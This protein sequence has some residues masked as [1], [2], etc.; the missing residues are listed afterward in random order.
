MSK[1]TDYRKIALNDLIIGKGQARV[2]NVGAGIEDLADSIKVQG[3]LQP[4][5]VC[6]ALQEGKWEILSGQRRFL[7][8]KML[9]MENITAAILDERVEEAEAKAISITEN[10]IRRKLSGKEL[11]D[12]ITYLYRIYGTAKAVADTT[13]IPYNDVL[14]YV[15]YPRLV[16]EMKEMVDEGKVDVKV[17]LKA[18]D[19]AIEDGE[20]LNLETA[21]VLAEEME[22][23]TGV[24]RK[25][26]IKDRKE[27]PAKP[28]INV[29]E[30]SKTGSKV[31][32]IQVTVTQ[33][34]HNAL[35]KFAKE[36]ETTQDD[37]AAALIEEA[38]IGRG[39]LAE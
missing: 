39:F 27:N 23:M 5:I 9:K 6:E 7:A 4:I 20:T 30:D 33:D 31:T 16:P 18:Q 26:L 28:I 29:I 12:G 24:Q 22:K 37:A 1:I 38:L 14:H 34:T 11:I 15:K 21:I 3:L 36:E 8:H 25:K 35:Q 10:L 17:A 32:Q 2:Q 19:A 13:G